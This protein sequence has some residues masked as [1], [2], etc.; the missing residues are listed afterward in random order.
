MPKMTGAKAVVETLVKNKVGAVIGMTGHTV[1]EVADELAR[2]G[3]IKAVYTRNEVNGTYMAYGYNKIRPENPAVCLW[4]VAGMPHAA[5]GVMTAM[6]DSVPMVVLGGNVTSDALGRKD[7]Q[8]TPTAEMYAP[9]TKW[10]RRVANAAELPSALTK[11]LQVS[12]AGRPGPVVLDV[13]FDYFVETAEIDLEV[14]HVR[15]VAPGVDPE[16][17]ANAI[18]LLKNAKNPVIIAGGG[19]AISKAGDEV[20]ALAEALCIPVATGRSGSKGIFPESHELAIGTIGS[21]GWEIG[22]ETVANADCW[23]AIGCTFS[24]I[25]MQD[26]TTK[27]PETIIH[28]DIDPA[29]IGKIYKPTLGILADAKAALSEMLRQ[30]DIKVGDAARHTSHPRYAA[31]ADRKA[32]FMRKLEEKTH[33]HTSPVDPFHVVG[34][35]NDILPDDAI[36]VGGAGNNGEFAVHAYVSNKPTFMLS[37][38]Y[39]AV[40]CAFPMALGAKLAAPDVPVICIEGD[41]GVHYNITELGTAV[42]HNIPVVLI[43]YNDGHL[44]ANRQISNVLF[45]GKQTWTEINNPDWVQL[46]KSFGAEAERV[47]RGEDLEEAVKRAIASGKPYVLD[48]AIDP[49]VRGPVTGKL[50]KIRW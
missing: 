44:N 22:N 9:I 43:I 45:E 50:W 27:A 1:M 13:P 30:L 15:P 24:Q 19:V 36:I 23:L 3:Q 20:R 17:I 14:P 41:G 10:S 28:I 48:V 26:W 16:A 21:F 38:K 31:I 4:H 12:G 8:D 32:D 2:D 25:A 5:P 11:A 47:E 29:E 37:Q 35:L 39:S 49:N 42:Q 18:S 6:A 7:F 40:G 33:R 34:V 46:A